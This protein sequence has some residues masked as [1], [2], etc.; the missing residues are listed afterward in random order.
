MATP[1]RWNSQ[2]AADYSRGHNQN[3]HISNITDACAILLVDAHVISA[4]QG[5]TAQLMF[6]AILCGV[7]ELISS[8]VF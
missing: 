5:S 2:S 1:T 3:H 7:Q 6:S 8:S 4:A